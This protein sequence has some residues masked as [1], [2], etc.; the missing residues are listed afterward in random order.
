MIPVSCFLLEET[1]GTQRRRPRRA[2]PL[3]SGSG[4]SR[5]PPPWRSR[6]SPAGGLGGAVSVP[7]WQ[8]RG[9]R[10]RRRPRQTAGRPL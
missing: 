7:S 2:R 6:R 4:A 8:G 9:R 1:S 10:N 5:R 3:S